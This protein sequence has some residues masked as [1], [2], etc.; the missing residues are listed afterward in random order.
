MAIDPKSLVANGYDFIAETYLQRYVR[1]AVRD[2]WFG[3]LIALL[4]EGSAVLDLG[5]GAGI[6]VA[7]DLAGRGF[8][9]VGVDN[10]ARQIELA[11]RNVPTAKF[12]K[13]DMTTVGF[14][15]ASFD[16]VCAFY[17]ITHIPRQEHAALLRR[18][19]TWLRPRGIFLASLGAKEVRNWTGNWLGVEMFFSHFG[20]EANEQLLRDAGFVIEHARVVEQDNED[21]R[22]LWVV[23]RVEA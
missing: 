17:S 4:P 19:A 9:V 8:R 20:A 5:C 1:S 13:A 6:P 10:S 18:I 2:H 23:A 11:R 22:F 14:T 16:G 15:P 3:E 7:D 21:A 12:F